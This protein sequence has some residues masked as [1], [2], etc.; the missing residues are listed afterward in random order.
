MTTRIFLAVFFILLG[1]L[2]VLA[3]RMDLGAREPDPAVTVQESNNVKTVI[4]FEIGAFDRQAVEINGE[5]YF[6]LKCA[7]EGILHNAGEPALPR[8]C[9]SIVIPD[10]GR[11]AIEVIAAEYVDLPETPIAPSKGNILRTV[12]PEDVPYSF[13][14]VYNTSDWYPGELAALREPFILR[15]IRGTVIELNAFQYHPVNK[16]LRVYTSV[17]VEVI[18]VGAGETNV[19]R[20]DAPLTGILSDY[21][22]IYER[23]FVNYPEMAARYTPV[24]EAGEMLIITYDGFHETMLPFVEWKMQKGIKTTI[25]DISAIGNNYT[26]IKDFVQAF[27]DSTSLGWLLLVGDAAQVS[28]GPGF[29]DPYYSKLAGADDYPDIFVGRFSAQNILEAETQVERSIEYEKMPWGSDWFHKACGIASDQG[30]GHYGELDYEHSDLIRGK[31]LDY[32][33][34]FVDQIYDPLATTMD[35]SAAVND[36]RSYINYTGH[37]S[38]SS[39]STSHFTNTDVNLLTNDFMLPFIFSVACF[40]GNFVYGTCFAEAWLRATDNGDPSGAIATYM[41]VISQAWD[42][43]MDAQDEAADLLVAEE[44]LTVG[45]LCYNGSCR[46]IDINGPDGVTEFD[47]WTIFGDPSLMLR[48]DDPVPMVV[49]HD[50]GMIHTAG[51]L[52]V[53]AVGIEGAL[54]ALYHNG[55]LFGSAYTG[56]D[57]IAVIPIESEMPID[58]IVIL[59]VTAYNRSPYIAGIQVTG[60]EGPFVVYDEYTIDDATGNDDGLVNCGESIDLGLQLINVGPDT[61]YY[62]AVVLSTADAY[63]TVTDDSATY[64]LIPGD[65]GVIYIADAFAFEVADETVNG[66]I[67]DFE[68]VVTD[69]GP[70]DTSWIS[71][72]S[73]PV[74]CYPDLSLTPDSLDIILSEGETTMVPIKICNYGK[75]PL[76][77]SFTSSDHWVYLE[78]IQYNIPPV[79]SLYVMVGLLS[80]TLARGLHIGTIEY[81]CNDPD[82]PNGIIPV[83]LTITPPYT[84]GDANDDDALDMVDIL[85]IIAYLYKGGPPPVYI[86][87]T[88]VDG[89]GTV[90][91]LDIIVLIQYLYRGGV[92]LN[93]P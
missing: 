27:Y 20:R 3:E 49:Y 92:G 83:A 5:N 61:A 39:W 7:E 19:L 23:R 91:M 80:D 1:P 56:S 25:V 57:G 47:A 63:V 10:D 77:I 13:G 81:S 38:A 50:A 4:R 90:D 34:T 67:I 44:K 75:A 88:D 37:G 89:S 35:V 26:Y 78:S 60:P 72:F 54:C 85:Y 28:S 9:R 11:M 82:T 31:F 76:S 24:E 64:G 43:P 30:P 17:T 16:I 65:Y 69:S 62:V 29:S 46:M 14:P 8:L 74:F 58:E 45:G 70:A 79:D 41:S 21:R 53:E 6:S 51:Q 42:P 55:I 18:N 93:C 15:D 36:G 2:S 59:T 71:S 52:Q 32:N 40:N 66:H 73:I 48:T 84:C 12:N 33:F 22:L 68:L 87:A 86:E